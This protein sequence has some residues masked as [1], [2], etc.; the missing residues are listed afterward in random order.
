MTTDHRWRGVAPYVLT[1]GIAML[2]L[3]IMLAAFGIPEEGPLHPWAG[4]V[5]RL[6]VAVW[7]A[8][9]IVLATRSLR[10]AR[11]RQAV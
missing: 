11:Q 6:A 10:L 5:Q 3:F 2:V 4:A 9:L 7:F 1:S 8:C